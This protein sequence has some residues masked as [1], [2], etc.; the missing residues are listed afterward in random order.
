MALPDVEVSFIKQVFQPV[1]DIHVE[2]YFSEGHTLE[3]AWSEFLA[4][5]PEGTSA[6]TEFIMHDMFKQSWAGLALADE[7]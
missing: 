6:E 4:L 5:K 2:G 7:E 1:V 3:S